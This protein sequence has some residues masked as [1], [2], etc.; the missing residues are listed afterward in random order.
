MTTARR[1]A[2]EMGVELGGA[3]GYHVR[4][5]RC[6][7]SSTVIKVRTRGFDGL[8]LFAVRRLFQLRCRSSPMEFC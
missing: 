8:I 6:T 3:V 5:D 7:S 4:Y 1:I 2:Q